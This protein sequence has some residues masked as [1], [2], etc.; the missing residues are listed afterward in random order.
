MIRLIDW[1]GR[2]T[3]FNMRVKGRQGWLTRAWRFAGAYFG[4]STMWPDL[5]IVS[6]LRSVGGAGFRAGRRRAASNEALVGNSAFP[7]GN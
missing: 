2:Y 4:D 6:G 5:G 3:A 7:F 1:A